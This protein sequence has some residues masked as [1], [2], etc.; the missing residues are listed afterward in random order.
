MTDL[1]TSPA[2]IAVKLRMIARLTAEELSGYEAEAR[3]RGMYDGEA[4]ALAE[5]RRKVARNG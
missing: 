5:R 3:E 2:E 4:A 1:P